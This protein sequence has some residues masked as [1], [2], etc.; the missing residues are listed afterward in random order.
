M[1]HIYKA[2]EHRNSLRAA[3][4]VWDEPLK[5]WALSDA[6]FSK[7]S[8]DFVKVLKKTRAITIHHLPKV[9]MMDWINAEELASL[10][11][12]FSIKVQSLETINGPS[13]GVVA[14]VSTNAGLKVAAVWAHDYY[15]V[16]EGYLA[17]PRALHR[18]GATKLIKTAIRQQLPSEFVEA[19]WDRLLD[20]KS[21]PDEYSF[22]LGITGAGPAWYVDTPS[23][24]RKAIS[25]H[26]SSKLSF[27]I[28]MAEEVED[29]PSMDTPH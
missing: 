7:L 28:S 2:F 11:A 9:E 4:G 24:L 10:S 1:Y 6:C 13:Q 22:L 16:K 19:G 12:N 15:G 17:A 8:E 18:Y 25:Q 14:L 21:L 26:Q 27:N 20:F 23:S 3:G 29:R 5:A